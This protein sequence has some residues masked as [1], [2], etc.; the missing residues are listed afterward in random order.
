[1]RTI[2]IIKKII[3]FGLFLCSIIIFY[4]QNTVL[5][6]SYPEI[7]VEEFLQE[8]DDIAKMA[9]R[10]HYIYESSSVN[11]PCSDGKITCDRIISR[12]LWNLG[13]TDQPV[14]GAFFIG[15]YDDD[16]LQRHG[17]VYVRGNPDEVQAGDIVLVT[18]HVFV[19]ADYNEETGLCSKYDMGDQ[20]RIDSPQPF[21]NV[22]VL[23]AG[24]AGRRQFIGYY[25]LENAGITNGNAIK[26]KQLK[27]IVNYQEGKPDKYDVYI[28]GNDLE[29]EIEIPLVQTTVDYILY[30]NKYISDISLLDTNNTSNNSEQVLKFVSSTAIEKKEELWNTIGIWTRAGF[31]ASLYLSLAAMLTILVFIS[32]II[33]KGTISSTEEPTETKEKGEKKKKLKF[34]LQQFTQSLLKKKAIEEWIK[35]LF[36]LIL[37]VIF[38]Y[39]SVYLSNDLSKIINTY[40]DNESILDSVIVYAKAKITRNSTISSSSVDTTG[41]GTKKIITEATLD[42]DGNNL[43][44]RMTG[45]DTSLHNHTLDDLEDSEHQHIELA[46]LI[47]PYY[48]TDGKYHEDGEMVVNSKAADEVLLIFQELYHIQYPIHS[49]KLVDD[50]DGNDDKSMDANNTSAFNYREASDSPGTLSNHAGGFAIDINPKVNPYIDNY[51]VKQADGSFIKNSA[52]GNDNKYY[53]RD[54]MNG[55]ND[56]EKAQVIRRDTQIYDIF[57]RYGWNWLEHAGPDQCNLDS[58]HFDKPKNSTFKTINQK[59]VSKS[60]SV[61]EVEFSMTTNYEGL[62]M[63]LSNYNYNEHLLQN[64]LYLVL[65]IIF[66]LFKLFLTGV[67]YLRIVAVGIMVGIYPIII[68]INLFNKIYGNKGILVTYTKKFMFIV[69]LVPVLQ[70]VYY[71]MSTINP[72][73]KETPFYF[74]F[75]EIIMVLI[76]KKDINLILG[77]KKKNKNK[78]EKKKK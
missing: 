56:I 21:Q 26:N 72:F 1:M 67:L 47:I 52:L 25:R 78:K 75:V 3:F 36:A 60:N 12:A 19:V 40:K 44:E 27:E 7:T 6:D 58:Q 35:S 43:L 42:K 8:C 32:V 59:Y 18:G 30:K 71:I 15:G 76:I 31:K 41:L 39:M 69:F 73:S 66:T 9:R 11:P 22:G 46:Y 33:V 23:D 74:L 77:R 57:H 28:E 5:A 54:N 50:F 4:P 63:L 14:G 53:D 34:S 65:G 13:M 45:R 64:I 61:R 20:W 24:W 16:W 62:C 37:M 49:L 29:E 55:W 51:W 68:I 70:L 10:D 17:F 38:V 2:K 48:G